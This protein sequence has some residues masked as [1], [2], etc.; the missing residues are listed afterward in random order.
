MR[1]TAFEKAPR[2]AFVVSWLFRHRCR[3]W[4]RPRMPL[5]KLLSTIVTRRGA[6]AQSDQSKPLQAILNSIPAPGPSVKFFTPCC[7]HHVSQYDEFLW[8]GVSRV[9]RASTQPTLTLVYPRIRNL[10]GERTTYRI[11]WST[12]ALAA[13][14]SLRARPRRDR[15]R[16]RRNPA[17]D[18]GLDLPNKRSRAHQHPLEPPPGRWPSPAQH[19]RTCRRQP[20]SFGTL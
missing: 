3:S 14:V 5:N 18:S 20:I 12:D 15:D 7:L 2:F 11:V 13:R 6:T 19:M 8:N 4:L 10:F 17:Q 1:L 16:T 9:G